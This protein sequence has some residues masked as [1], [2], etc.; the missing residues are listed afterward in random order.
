VAGTFALTDTKQPQS[1]A[2]R[3]ARK[4]R[5]ILFVQRPLRIAS[6]HAVADYRAP[7]VVPP[8]EPVGKVIFLK[9]DLS[10]E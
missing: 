8:N 9:T 7:A 5:K 3:G 4:R 6:S 10:P 1:I 2:W